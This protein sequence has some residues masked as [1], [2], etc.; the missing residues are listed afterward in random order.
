MRV[1]ERRG[2]EGREKKRGEKGRGGERRGDRRSVNAAKFMNITHAKKKKNTLSFIHCTQS[3]D[4]PLT[5]SLT[6]SFTHLYSSSLP[7]LTYKLHFTL[8]K[9]TTKK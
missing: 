1:K 6:H 4:S 9:N 2:E 7:Y 5:H 8:T 3:Q